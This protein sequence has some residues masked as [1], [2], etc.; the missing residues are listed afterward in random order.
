MPNGPPD[1]GLWVV[2]EPVVVPDPVAVDVP[3]PVPVPVAVAVAVAGVVT[4]AVAGGACGAVVFVQ[5]LAGPVD[6]VSFVAVVLAGGPTTIRWLSGRWR[7][8]QERISGLPPRVT[9]RTSAT[10]GRQTGIA[11]R[12]DRPRTRRTCPLLGTAAITSV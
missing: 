12:T 10:G 6:V 1:A 11:P 2:S 7:I 3:V 5:P 8:P 9:L 4:V